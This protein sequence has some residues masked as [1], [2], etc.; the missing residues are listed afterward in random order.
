MVDGEDAEALRG[1]HWRMRWWAAS[2]T[3]A[4]NRTPAAIGRTVYRRYQCV[5]RSRPPAGRA[6]T[7]RWRHQLG[8]EPRAMTLVAAQ[9]D[10]GEM[11]RGCAVTCRFVPTVLFPKSLALLG[12]QRCRAV[13]SLEPEESALTILI[14]GL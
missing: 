12:K 5:P 14:V 4:L 8:A 3:S 11:P 6:L 7:G 1:L 13:R 9:R 2:R 10:V